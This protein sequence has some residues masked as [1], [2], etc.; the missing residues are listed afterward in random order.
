LKNSQPQ[1][2]QRRSKRC[3]KE[4]EPAPRARV[5]KQ[6]GA[7]VDAI[8]RI[9]HLFRPGKAVWN[10]AVEPEKVGVREKDGMP[11]RTRAKAAAG[12]NINIKP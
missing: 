12:S 11:D 10:P 6:A 9:R 1:T 5:Q 8:R 2:E 7:K 3:R 4:T